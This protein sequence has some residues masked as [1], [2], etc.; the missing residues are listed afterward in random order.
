MGVDVE[1]VR[2]RCIWLLMTMMVG[3]FQGHQPDTTHLEAKPGIRYPAESHQRWKW[4]LYIPAT[5]SAI[6][7]QHLASSANSE[8]SGCANQQM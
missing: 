7:I 8:Q 4:T 2:H 1:V 3:W 5:Y 6:L